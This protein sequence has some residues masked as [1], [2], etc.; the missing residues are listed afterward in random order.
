MSGPTVLSL[1]VHAD[2]VRARL[3]DLVRARVVEQTWSRDTSLWATTPEAA[4]AV[5]NRLGWLD[6]P[7][8]AEPSRAEFETFA[9]RVRADGF[10]HVML[11]GMG[12]SSLCP[13]VLRRTFPPANGSPS[14][15]VLDSTD[16]VTVLAA[17]RAAPLPRTL[18]VVST[19]S[20]TTIETVSLLRY[21][22]EV[23][24]TARPAGAAAAF[25]AVTDPGTPLDREA[26]ERGWR[27]VFS[28][29]PD[30]GGRYSALTPFG[31][32]P[33][34]LL[35]VDLGKLIGRA[36]RMR[37]SCRARGEEN[38]GLVLGAALAELARAGRDKVTFVVDP[39]LASFGLWAEQLLAESLGKEGK[40]LVPVAGEP[41]GGPD[42]YGQDRLFV[43]LGM[44]GARGPDGERLRRLEAAGHPVIRIALDDA[45]DLGAEFFRWE[46]ATAV[47]AVDLGVNAFDEPNVGESKE[48]TG[49]VLAA[50][51][52][53]D[54][55]ERET[56]CAQAR[57]VRLCGPPGLPPR[58]GGAGGEE[59]L[60]GLLRQWLDAIPAGHYLAVQAYLPLDERTE[61]RLERIR[62]RLRD[63]QRL[64]V[65]LGFG[66][67]YLHST[68]QL[69]K[70]GPPTGAFLQ[71]TAD[72]PAELP[73]P[74]GGFGFEQ[75]IRAQ[76]LGDARSLAGRNLPVLRLQLTVDGDL[77][78][79]EEW[80][81]RLTAIRGAP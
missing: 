26:R 2:R 49:R 19:K 3:A 12:G 58:P 20:G 73:V 30:V 63:R 41:L 18:F 6:A 31:L 76:A 39:P 51:Q 66:P 11:L 52:A 9:A 33:A 65:T 56:P 57:G 25:V 23:C 29:P 61:A 71:I 59:E 28:G 68:G 38:P 69:H 43:H 46:F 4:R 14:L 7:L 70:G 64:A 8:A 1:G 79:V 27:H 77:G 32:L 80:L 45:Y 24:E 72:T 36:G 16:P 34:A 47:A 10:V 48:N 37:E 22:W 55:S 75:L 40:G 53:T 21:F 50:Y 81:E 42:V 35:G 74:G 60:I 78:A 15:T 44:H 67:R 17:Q 54:R 62:A 13:E 5:A